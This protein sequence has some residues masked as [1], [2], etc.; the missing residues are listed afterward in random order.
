MSERKCKDWLKTFV[1]WGSVGEAPFHMLFWTGVSTVA[2]ALRRKVWI[3]MRFFQWTPNFYIVLVAP[4]G[5]VSKSTTA[6]IGMNL[7]REVNGI[8]F[9]PD[10][11]TWQALVESLAKSTEAFPDPATGEFLAMSAITIAS[12]EFGTFLNPQDREMVDVLVSLWDG[13]KGVF[14]KMTKTSGNDRI[15]NPWVNIIACTTPS[16]ISGNFPEYMIGGGF[17]S[18]CVFLYTETKRQLC[19]YPGL[20]SAPEY[21]QVKL[22]LIHDLED[23]STMTGEYVLSNEAVTWGS[24]WYEQHWK[25]KPTNL[26]LDQFGG[27]LARKQTH[28]HKLAMVL[29]AS[30]SSEL[31]LHKH[32]I[33][34][35]SVMVTSLEETMPK[36]F[37]KIGQTDITRSAGSLVE[38]VTAAGQ[39]P[40][41]TLYRQMFR[42]TSAADFELALKG[43]IMAG[44]VEQ[45]Q[46]G[47]DLII[48]S[49]S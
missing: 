14:S 45:V 44:H 8:K 38:I 30:E 24:E 11:V 16:W 33:E 6:N 40:R 35:A 31:I 29:A 42:Y 25:T 7:L 41:S 17:T 22:D 12:D 49:K 3:D 15:E 23:I 36:V 32:H 47:N 43:A 46:H 34:S 39:L 5:V 37:A 1:Q 13:K 10:V 20:V 26:N 2:G 28:I 18:R 21:D 19:A 9:G 4:P 48:R 27:Y